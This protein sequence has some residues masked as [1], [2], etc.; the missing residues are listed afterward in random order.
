VRSWIHNA[1]AK[2][3][4]G[5]ALTIATVGLL[6]VMFIGSAFRMSNIT[7]LDVFSPENMGA[8]MPLFGTAAAVV[9]VALSLS[10]WYGLRRKG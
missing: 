9:I 1:L 7:K 3:L 2:I 4:V 10:A 6:T 8:T 5:L